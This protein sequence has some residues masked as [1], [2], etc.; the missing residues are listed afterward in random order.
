MQ[1][2][3]WFGFREGY[4]D[5]VR[6]FIGRGEKVG[7]KEIDLYEAFEAICLDEESFRKE[8]AQYSEMVDGVPQITPAQVPPLVSQHLPWLKPT[9]PKKMYNARLVEIASPGEW[10]EPTAYPATSKDLA[11]NTNLWLPV[12]ESLS[13]RP[14]RFAC[15]SDDGKKYSFD[16]LKGSISPDVFLDIASSLKWCAPTQFAPHLAYL[17]EITGGRHAQVEEWAVL[18]PQL[19]LSKGTKTSEGGHGLVLGAR[20]DSVSWFL[21]SRRRNPLFGAIS[22]PKH[23][24]VPRRI[25]GALATE[26]N[27]ETKALTGPR[28]GAILLYP[29]IERKK[30]ANGQDK[31]LPIRGDGSIDPGELVIA[32]AFVAPT[33][34]RAGDGRVV[35]FTTVDS[36]REGT[37]IIDVKDIQ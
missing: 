22:E 35:R 25:A 29:V 24:T 37:P 32:F 17:R 2:G 21:R 8:L 9:S 3:R 23:R 18:A 6:L 12:L 31:P 30:D 20:E 7:K 34:A 26:C 5:L 27:E 16:A 10:V 1:M 13:S 28:K 33:S 11:H 15:Y 36:S 19:G 4:R 14:V